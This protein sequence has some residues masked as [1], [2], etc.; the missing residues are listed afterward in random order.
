[1]KNNTKIRLHLSK[2]LFESLTKQVITEAK[3]KHYGAGMKE[4]KAPKKERMEEMETEAFN[5]SK[6]AT[7]QMVY[8]KSELK[9]KLLQIAKQMDMMKG[10]GSAETAALAKLIDDLMAKLQQPDNLAPQVN[11]AA[12]AFGNATKNVST[13]A[14]AKD[15]SV[16]EM[17]TRV[18]EKES[19]HQLKELDS[20]NASLYDIGVWASDLLNLELKDETDLVGLGGKVLSAGTA[21]AFGVATGLIMYSD[22]IKSGIKKAGALL[23]NLAKGGGAVK[24]DTGADPL[25]RLPADALAALKK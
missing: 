14:P 7:P 21:G 8:S 22:Q 25:E 2:Q 4:V 12:K 6:N 10:L 23:K 11:M 5:V 20:T 24:E 1:M 19:M 16:K 17:E 13:A 15:K 3:T 18:A 9:K